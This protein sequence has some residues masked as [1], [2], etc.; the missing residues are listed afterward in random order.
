MPIEFLKKKTELNPSN[1]GNSLRIKEKSLLDLNAIE[2]NEK[3]EIKEKEIA[4]NSN[5]GTSSVNTPINLICPTQTNASTVT[6]FESDEKLILQ[7]DNMKA[8]YEEVEM[9]KKELKSLKES[10]NMSENK[11]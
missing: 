7:G 5:T 11:T 9:I 8:T 10:S 6:N 2:N 3:K 1:S 4:V